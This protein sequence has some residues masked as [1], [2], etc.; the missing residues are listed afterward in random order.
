[1][2]R[3]AA[4]RQSCGVW[5]LSFQ[6]ERVWTFSPL[7]W[8][9]ASMSLAGAGRMKR[10]T[11]ESKLLAQDDSQ[12]VKCS[13]RNNIFH[14]NK[15]RIRCVR[16]C[17]HIYQEEK[18]PQS[19]ELCIT[20]EHLD[21]RRVVSTLSRWL[22]ASG[23]WSSAYLTV[24]CCVCTA[25]FPPAAAAD[26]SWTSQVC[27]SAAL[28]ALEGQTERRDPQLEPLMSNRTEA[29]LWLLCSGDSAAASIFSEMQNVTCWRPDYCDSLL[30][31]NLWRDLRRYKP[32]L[33][34]L[35]SHLVCSAVLTSAACFFHI[36]TLL[37]KSSRG[38]LDTEFCYRR[39]GPYV[40][41]TVCVS[42]TVQ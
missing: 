5:V 21:M 23:G 8:K 34:I 15:R 31:E 9:A 40:T 25:G 1:M 12:I 18:C 37:F 20:S 10:T 39:P 2:W 29:R 33:L 3:A 6:R 22:K 19:D 4:G 41:F 14:L 30:I 24:S 17:F 13:L 27:T 36:S 42:K 11:T 7:G 28:E 26:S 35:R 38:Q 16:E 32:P